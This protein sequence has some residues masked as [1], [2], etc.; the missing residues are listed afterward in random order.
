M[1]RILDFLS[2]RNL[3][4]NELFFTTVFYNISSSIASAITASITGNTLGTIQASCLPFIFKIS[5]FISLIFIVF[6][7]KLIDEVGL[8]TTE[9]TSGIPVESPPKIPPLLLVLVFISLL[10][11]LESKKQFIAS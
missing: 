4:S 10:H 5:S 8:T 9:N 11:R 7:S 1:M 3:A 2:L 6:C